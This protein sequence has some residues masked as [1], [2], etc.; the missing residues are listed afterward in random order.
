[1][2]KQTVLL[3]IAGLLISANFV[4]AEDLHLPDPKTLTDTSNAILTV[5]TYA[6]GVFPLYFVDSSN[7]TSCKALLTTAQ[8]AYSTLTNE[9]TESKKLFKYVAITSTD[10]TFTTGDFSGQTVKNV[11]SCVAA[12]DTK[13]KLI[14]KAKEAVR[15]A[16]KRLNKLTGKK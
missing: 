11:S 3:S 2:N 9:G 5:E 10:Y 13:A 15:K 8:S 1:M 4:W 6:G 7:L 14:F 12:E 16:L